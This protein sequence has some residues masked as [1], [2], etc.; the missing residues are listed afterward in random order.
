MSA[1]ALAASHAALRTLLADIRDEYARK[2]PEQLALIDS[3]WREVAGGSDSRREQLLR[4]AH[5][6]AGAAATFGLPRVGKAALEL[7]RVLQPVCTQ[8]AAP[9]DRDRIQIEDRIAQLQISAQ[10]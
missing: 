8:G 9:S 6:M 3:L 4:A 5:S 7:E 2:L 10:P 1:P